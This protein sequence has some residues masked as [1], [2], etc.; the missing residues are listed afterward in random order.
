MA[1]LD[2]SSDKPAENRFFNAQRLTAYPLIFLTVYVIAAAAWLSQSA[3]MLD[4]RDKPI[5]YD[6]VTFWGA[7]WLALQGQAAAA[8]DPEV[9]FAAEQ[10]AVPGSEKIYLWHYPPTFMLIIAPL[11]LIPYIWSYLIWVFSTF[12]AY[13]WV[14]RKMAPQPQTLLLL[15]AFPGAFMNLFHGQNGFLTAALFGGAM[16]VLERRPVLAGILIG[17]LSLK[18][19]FGLL[20]PL[21]LLFGRH[22]SAFI[23][24]AATTLV[25]ALASGL[26]FG[27]ETWIAFFDN[28][29]LARSVFEDGLVRWSKIPSLYATL[30][31]AGMGTGG[32]LALQIAL[33]AMVAGTVCWMWWKKPPLP[34]RA[35]V[36]V[37]GSLLVT[38]YLFDY[39]Y[40]LLAIP[41]ALLAMDGYVR[42]WMPGDRAVL[43]VAWIMPLVA[44]G[45]ADAIN[46]QIGALCVIALFVVAVHRAAASVTSGRLQEES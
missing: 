26:A 4:P 9:M 25:F 10:V 43:A 17:L 44:R 29:P 42:G 5:G 20:I 46:V 32:A 41:I 27:W 12:A 45:I 22:W 31:L 34:L 33:A 18:P 15:V 16:L 21:A 35:A 19:Q 14:V 7:S 30:R 1:I 38:P 13:G 3:D 28:L 39:D 37:A 36:L 24:A 2:S 8:F 11:S 40:A 23:A 6:F